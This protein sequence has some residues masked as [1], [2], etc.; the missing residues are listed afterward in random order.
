MV[1]D[2]GINIGTRCNKHVAAD[3]DAAYDNGIGADPDVIAD[4]G[5]AGVFSAVG[6]P[7]RDACC[8]IHILPH[9]NTGVYDDAS[10]MADVKAG[11]GANF[12]RDLDMS[13]V[14]KVLKLKI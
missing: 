5:N 3:R 8:E 6:L 2:I 9:F 12:G 10:E 13:P 11:S 14:H 1:G 7:D 4:N